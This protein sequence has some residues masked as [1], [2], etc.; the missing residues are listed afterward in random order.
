MR[1]IQCFI[2]CLWILSNN[3]YCNENNNTTS[4]IKNFANG[5]LDK[6]SNMISDDGSISD[7]ASFISNPSNSN[8]SSN[9]S[10]V[11]Q[12]ITALGNTVSS[13]ANI[14]TNISNV[15]SQVS[16]LTNAGSVSSVKNS[17]PSSNKVFNVVNVISG[18]DPNLKT[19]VS[20]IVESLKTSISN[21]VSKLNDSKIIESSDV[22]VIKSSLEENLNVIRSN[23]GEKLVDKVNSINSANS[24]LLEKLKSGLNTC[25]VSL[26]SNSVNEATEAIKSITAEFVELSNKVIDNGV[27]AV[28]GSVA[29]MVLSNEDLKKQAEELLSEKLLLM[30]NLGVSEEQIAKVQEIY[31]STVKSTLE[32]VALGDYAGATA[33]LTAQKEELKEYLGENV[34]SF[35]NSIEEKKQELTATLL[36]KTGIS[37]AEVGNAVEEVTKTINVGSIA[38]KVLSGD[39]ESVREEV[40]N[41]MHQ[42]QEVAAANA[43]SLINSAGENLANKVLEKTGLKEN[44]IASSLL[45]GAINSLN[46][47]GLTSSLISGGIKGLKTTASDTINNIKSNITRENIQ[48]KVTE[49]VSSVMEQNGTISNV[50]GQIKNWGESLKTSINNSSIGITAVGTAL[51]TIVDSAVA[52]G[53]EGAITAVNQ[54]LQGDVSGGITALK[55]SGLSLVDSSISTSIKVAESLITSGIE[56]VNE[57]INGTIEKVVGKASEYENII[58]ED[59]KN[60]TN[61]NKKSMQDYIDHLNTEVADIEIAEKERISEEELAEM[62]SYKLHESIIAEEEMSHKE[63]AIHNK[64]TTSNTGGN[65]TN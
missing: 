43:E 7:G 59:K 28:A 24:T 41:T 65:S 16:S 22:S 5:I 38:E 13:V 51:T 1:V 34:E 14:T 53:N 29:E 44:S 64:K 33:D 3:L 55:N 18:Q 12:G 56:N 19:T 26:T 20:S 30:K 23:I 15:A 39:I 4:T 10:A 61:D 45:S 42:V 63:A 35:S 58:A 21:T 17:I 54:I 60:E 40:T 32:K 9:Q 36:E 6:F 46:L 47:S 25:V 57:K 2:C 50:Q 48:N 62:E 11:Q 49:V 8:I 27:G 37:D 52:N 31:D